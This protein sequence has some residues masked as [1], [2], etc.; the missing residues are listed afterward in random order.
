MKL[1]ATKMVASNFFGRSN[2]FE[3]I[4]NAFGFSSKPL[5]ISVRVNEKK[6]TSAPEIKAEHNN[7]MTSKSIPETND[8]FAVKKNK[9][10]L[11]GSGSKVKVFG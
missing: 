2:S 10:K 11:K 6:A 1:F 9:I 5:S 8:A 4:L 7:R 3:M